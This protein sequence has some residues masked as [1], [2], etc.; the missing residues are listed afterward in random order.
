MRLRVE[1]SLSGRTDQ[2][3]SSNDLSQRVRCPISATRRSNQCTHICKEDE[4][5]VTK[6]AN[7]G[8]GYVGLVSGACFADF[9]SDVV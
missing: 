4:L 9:G 8:S 1:A 7:V 3:R 6:I 2:L 5:A